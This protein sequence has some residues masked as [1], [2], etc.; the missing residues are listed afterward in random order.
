MVGSRGGGGVGRGDGGGGRGVGAHTNTHI[1]RDGKSTFILH[2]SRILT[3]V[4]VKK[5]KVL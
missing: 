5:C 2:S 1:I 3:Q 4:K